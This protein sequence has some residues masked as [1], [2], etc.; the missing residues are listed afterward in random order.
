M[1]TYVWYAHTKNQ[2]DALAAASDAQKYE[3]CRQENDRLKEQVSLFK[4]N[5]Q[6][7]F[8]SNRKTQEELDYLKA[9][10]SKGNCAGLRLLPLAVLP[11][12]SQWGSCV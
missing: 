4:A 6:H 9:V 8:E 11:V 3:D 5:M 2:S 12:T 1:S 7:M 10:Q